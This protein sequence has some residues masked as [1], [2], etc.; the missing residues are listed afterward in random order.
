METRMHQRRTFLTG[1]AA[2][3]LL[4][5]HAMAR[6]ALPRECA[7]ILGLWRSDVARTMAHFSVQGRRPSAEQLQKISTLFGKITHEFLPGRLV[8][9]EENGAHV[10]RQAFG[11]RVDGFTS[12]TV[13]LVLR[14]RDRPPGMTLYKG[15]GHYFVRSG[16]HL[17]YFKRQD[18]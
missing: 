5:G 16:N 15:D 3:A 17:E 4:P 2:S 1:L 6:P 10:R 11:F 8:V 7:W 14:G 18:A 9:R 12:S 13:S